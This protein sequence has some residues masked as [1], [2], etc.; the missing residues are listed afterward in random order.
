[1]SI[2]GISSL[3]KI[4]STK[5]HYR[6]S[7]ILKQLNSEIRLKLNSDI[8][9]QVQEG[10][11]IIICRISLDTNSVEFSSALHKMVLLRKGETTLFN[12]CRHFIGNHFKKGFEFIEHKLELKKDDQIF[13]FS[14][15]FYDQKGGDNGRKLYFKGFE[16]ILLKMANIPVSEQENYLTTKMKNWQGEEEQLD[17][18]LVFGWKVK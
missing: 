3:D 13:M 14:D 17:D 18:M 2:V 7:Q 4:V 11:D 9:E 16:E 6:P 5:P 15:G 12:G 1:M 10:M 8:D